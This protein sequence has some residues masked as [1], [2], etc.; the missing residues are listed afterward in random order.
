MVQ[1]SF[2]LQKRLK[3]YS[4]NWI[5]SKFSNDPKNVSRHCGVHYNIKNKHFKDFSGGGS[6]S[7]PPMSNRVK[8][9][10]FVFFLHLYLWIK[11][12]SIRRVWESYRHSQNKVEDPNGDNKG[13]E[14]RKESTQWRG[15]TSP[16][17]SWFCVSQVKLSIL[18]MIITLLSISYR[19]TMQREMMVGRNHRALLEEGKI[20]F[21]Q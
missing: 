14:G 19:G 12:Y 2:Q 10:I 3:N 15:Q 7:P 13:Q 18:F 11:L 16:Y 8:K 17:R 1:N 6:W 5:F 9:V 21:I 20:S 4:K